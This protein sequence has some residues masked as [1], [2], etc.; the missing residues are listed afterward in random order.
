MLIDLSWSLVLSA[1]IG[2]YLNESTIC[3]FWNDKFEFHLLHKSDYISFVGINIKSFDD[4]RGQ[5]IVDKRLKEKDIQNKNLFLDDLVIKIIISIEV[6]HCETFVVFDKDIDRFVNAFTKASVYSI[7]RSLHNKFVF[8]HIA[9]ELPESHHHFF[10]D[11]PNILFVVRD[12]SSASSFDIKTNK[13]VG[14]K[15]EKPSQMILVDRYLA[16]EQRFQFG[17]SLFA[18][19]LNNMQ[20][21]EVII[22]GFDYPPYTVI[23]HNMSTNAQDMGVSEDS[24]FKNV[25]IDGT[26]TRIILN[27]CEKFN[28]TIQIDS[29]LLRFKGRQHN[30]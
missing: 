21:R 19:K 14:R 2:T 29:S 3:I 25:Y 12:H 23:K 8:A 17:I 15:E 24:D 26:E 7:W 13:F 20:G 16:L 10:E 4:N 18:D 9:Y 22:A 1:I 28:C 30:N 5:Y 11:Q 27:F 6:T